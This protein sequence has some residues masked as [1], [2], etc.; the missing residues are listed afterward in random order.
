M[1]SMHQPANKMRLQMC[2]ATET[3]Q[4]PPCMNGGLTQSL[5]TD[6]PSTPWRR[7]GMVTKVHWAQVQAEA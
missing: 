6:G 5:V 4:A 7:F 1:A 2:H 3:L